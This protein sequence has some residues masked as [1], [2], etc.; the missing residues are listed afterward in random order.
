MI[1]ILRK[2]QMQHYKGTVLQAVILLLKILSNS[3][4]F[5]ALLAYWNTKAKNEKQNQLVTQFSL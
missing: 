4:A 2:R 3:A 1:Y 5:I